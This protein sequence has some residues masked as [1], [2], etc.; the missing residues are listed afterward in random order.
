VSSP[1]Y[2]ARPET[3]QVAPSASSRFSLFCWHALLLVLSSHHH[4]SHPDCPRSSLTVA[5]AARLSPRPFPT[6][7][8]APPHPLSEILQK[9]T[10]TPP[11]LSV[12]RI[13]SFRMV[14]PL[15]KLEPT[16]DLAHT[17]R[18]RQPDVPHAWQLRLSRLIKNTASV[19]HLSCLT[20]IDL[21]GVTMFDTSLHILLSQCPTLEGLTMKKMLGI[22]TLLV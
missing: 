17:L 9:K 12:H 6:A 8:S 19:P 7:S 1:V 13:Q 15:M 3:P 21:W 16:K 11:L 10:L 2:F 14:Y 22:T 20:E 18:L 4:Y 5:S